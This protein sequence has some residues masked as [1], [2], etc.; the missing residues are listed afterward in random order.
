MKTTLMLVFVITMVDGRPTV[1]NKWLETCPYQKS[2]VLDFKKGAITG[3]FKAGVSASPR[4][5]Q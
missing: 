2:I 1:E 4:S 5:D 3:C